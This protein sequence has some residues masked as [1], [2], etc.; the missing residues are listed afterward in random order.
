MSILR[1]AAL[2]PLAA[3]AMLLPNVGC[4]YEGGPGYSADRHAY[5]SRTWSPKTITLTD[6]RS[7]EAV[8]SVDVPV[9]RKLVVSFRP[10]A[11]K[12]NDIDNPDLM[13]WDLI[14]PDTDFGTL[15]NQIP[16]PPN[17]ARI[18]DMTLRPV[19]E[20]ASA[21]LPERGPESPEEIIDVVE[22]QQ[23]EADA[24]PEQDAPEQDASPN[25]GK[26]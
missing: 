11:N 13:I 6:V 21:A 17:H 20:Y 9:D 10:G 12:D 15:D 2:I 5:V 1:R 24:D 3:A 7:G 18:L 26:R 8:W 16:V 22:D 25:D 23:D 4:Y 14:D 19:P